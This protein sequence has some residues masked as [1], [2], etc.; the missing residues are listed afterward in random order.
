MGDIIP[1]TRPTTIKP[2]S[3]PYVPVWT[4][5]HDRSTTSGKEITP[6]TMVIPR[7]A[8]PNP[9]GWVT[10]FGCIWENT[11]LE[12]MLKVGGRTYAVQWSGEGG[13]RELGQH[14]GEDVPGEN[15]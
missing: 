3:N 9:S 14:R 13:L 8:I 15:V 10:Q 6:R 12:A 5:V 2:S 4:R 1:R 7:V 11:S